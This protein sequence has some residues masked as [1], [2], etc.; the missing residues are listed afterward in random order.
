[1]RHVRRH[2]AD[3]SAC[4]FG[5]SSERGHT[6]ICGCIVHSGI[7]DGPVIHGALRHG[8]LGC[9]RHA[10]AA[11]DSSHSANYRIAGCAGHQRAVVSGTEQCGPPQARKFEH[12]SAW[13]EFE[14]SRLPAGRRRRARAW[15]SRKI[16]SDSAGAGFGR[17][18]RIFALEESRIRMAGLE[19]Q[20][21]GGCRERFRFDRREFDHA[22]CIQ[23]CECA[24]SG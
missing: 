12:R 11:A 9:S 24:G 6:D 14:Q 17:W 7:V 22:T 4:S 5:T 20:Q 21:A 10:R 8:S 13:S 19:F 2:A 3:G 16:C 23:S 1:L 18:A 15:R